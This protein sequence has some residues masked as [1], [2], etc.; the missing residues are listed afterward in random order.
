MAP[1]DKQRPEL[2]TPASGDSCRSAKCND[3][4]NSHPNPR[5]QVPDW[6]LHR[7]GGFESVTEKHRLAVELSDYA[8]PVEV[9]HIGDHDPSGA[10]LFLA[11]AEDVQAFMHWPVTFTRLAVIPEPIKALAL[12]TAPAKSTDRRALDGETCQAEAIPP[13]VLSA[14]VLDAIESRLDRS[15]YDNVL[16]RELAAR[17][18]LAEPLR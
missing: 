5:R 12:P 16:E 11:M 1:P 13:D 9:L 14:I 7:R 4:L 3:I 15:A 18:E 10:H 6:R 17:Q 8:E 2:A